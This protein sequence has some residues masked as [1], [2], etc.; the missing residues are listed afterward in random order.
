MSPDWPERVLATMAPAVVTNEPR[1]GS[2]WQARDSARSGRVIA[3]EVGKVTFSFSGSRPLDGYS[4]YSCDSF[5]R[6]YRPV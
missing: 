1:V 6:L 5:H 4:T 3:C 2:M